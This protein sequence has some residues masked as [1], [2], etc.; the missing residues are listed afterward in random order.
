[1]AQGQATEWWES[2]GGFFG[3]IYKEMDNSYEG[4][5]NASISLED[6]TEEEAEGVIRLCRIS[7]GDKLL[8]CPC[9][10]GRH[11]LALARKG[12]DVTGADINERFLELDRAALESSP[13]A[14]CHF[15]KQDMRDLNFDGE[16][17]ALINMFYSFGFFETDGENQKVAEAFSR[18]LKPGG[19]FLM[20]TH[21]TVP[22]LVSGELKN[23]QIRNLVTGKK[24]ELRRQYNKVTKREDGTWDLL[25]ENG[26]LEQKLTPYSV[27]LYT[28]SEWEE[29]CKSVGFSKVNCYGDWHGTPYS[30]SSSQLIA[31]AEK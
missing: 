24:L 21:V 12:I 19:R 20:H 17:D 14:N 31:V 29:F 27:R 16:F 15:I 26:T 9:G 6:R 18:A 8:D 4:H 30:D 5:L 11:S 13:M 23:H 25:D 3:D 28:A 22:R 1:M 2:Q 7:P 10:Y